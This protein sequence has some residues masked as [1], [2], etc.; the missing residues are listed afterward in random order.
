M[1]ERKWFNLFTVLIVAAVTLTLYFSYI[2]LNYD[3]IGAMAIIED[4]KVTIGATE[5]LTWSSDNLNVGDEILLV[6]GK[7]PLENAIIQKWNMLE[8][9]K[10]LEVLSIDGTKESLIVEGKFDGQIV[11]HFIVPIA[12]LILSLY[13]SYLIYKSYRKSENSAESAL[14]LIAFLLT[15]SLAYMCGGA[16]ARGDLFSRT[17]VV[18]LLLATPILYLQFMR[19]YYEEMNT[20]WFSKYWIWGC[21]VLL[22]INIVLSLL[23]GSISLPGTLV[24]LINLSSA[25]IVFLLCGVLILTGLKKV[26]YKT[27]KYMIRVLLLSNILAFAPFVLLYVLPFVL[28]KIEIVSPAFLTGFLIIIPF[29]LVYQFL[30][31]KIY[32]IEF[33]VGRFKYY[34]LLIT[35]P[36]IIA[37]AITMT[38]ATTNSTVFSI[39]MFL[40]LFGVMFGTLYLKE[41]LDYRFKLNKVSEKANYQDR[42]TAYTRKIRVARNIEEVSTLLKQNI[43]DTMLVTKAHRVKYDKSKGTYKSNTFLEVGNEDYQQVFNQAT[44]T[45]GEIVELDNGF[46]LNI[47]E[48]RGDVYLI[49]ALSDINTPKLT[50]DEKQWLNNLAYY[51]NVTLENFIKI[52]NLM[53]NLEELENNPIWLN[54]IVFNLEEKQRSSLAK[55]L[56]DAVLQDLIG[57]RRRMETLYLKRIPTMDEETEREINS[58]IVG[59]TDAI[60]TTRKTCNELRPH[61]LYDL[62]I[63]KALNKL[64]DEHNKDGQNVILTTNNLDSSIS[65]EVQLNIYRIAQE[66]L[67]NAEKHSFAKTVRLVAVKI[68]EKVVLHYED[69]GEGEDLEYI[70]NKEG[71]MGLSGIRERVRILNGDIKIETEPGQGFKVIVE[72]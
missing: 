38:V 56:H 45:L 44:K 49:I 5:P 72:I 61:L 12:I 31:T 41:V 36:S 27:Q 34:S 14:L 69:D 6:D 10:H 60:E 50:R 42:L 35:V 64:A 58:F 62:G 29:S 26:K 30:A 63:E 13:C 67:N 40:V 33:I 24:K 70:L 9:V 4:D 20:R 28:F 21:Y 51:T 46:V 65:E 66:L 2:I 25:L 1:K 15:F 71:S 39:R 68:K 37:V 18:P 52:E 8:Q 57:L 53:D 22:P 32:D 11:F 7:D 47:G 23:S 17:L 54:K 19:R 3:Y 55:D 59:M 43:T 48:T 16:S